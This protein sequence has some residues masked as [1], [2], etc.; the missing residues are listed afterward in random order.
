MLS[1]SPW[2]FADEVIYADLARSI[3]SGAVPAI[4]GVASHSFGLV[5]PALIAPAWVGDSSTDGLPSH[6]SDQR[7]R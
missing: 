1:R 5:Y 7:G 6:P 2:I 4:R 3:A